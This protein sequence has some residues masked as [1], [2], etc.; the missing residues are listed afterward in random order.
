MNRHLFGE[1]E[2]TPRFLFEL[3]RGIRHV[4][5]TAAVTDRKTIREDVLAKPDRHLGIERLHEAVA[6]NISRNNVRM[7]G[8]ENQIAVRVDP[9]PVKRHKA[10]LVAKRVEVVRE[11]AS[12]ILPA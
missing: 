10:T 2:I 11:P 5:T 8:A 3:A 9:R 12:K 4:E 6:K 1:T 7:S